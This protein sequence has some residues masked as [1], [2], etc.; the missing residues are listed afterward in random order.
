MEVV[1]KLQSAKQ[2]AQDTLA[3]E[4][5]VSESATG[6][7][8][9]SSH[10][11]MLKVR[12][13][14]LSLVI[15]CM[16]SD[17]LKLAVTS[18]KACVVEGVQN[19]EPFIERLGSLKPYAALKACLDGLVDMD[20][21]RSLSDHTKLMQTMK[22]DILGLVK[23]TTSAANKLKKAVDRHRERLAT[24]E[25]HATAAIPLALPPPGTASKDT[26]AKKAA[27]ST[28]SFPEIFSL[29]NLTEISK[30]VVPDGESLSD[31]F[32][33]NN[34]A[35]IQEAIIV[36]LQ[37]TGDKIQHDPELKNAMGMFWVD[38]LVSQ[39]YKSDHGRGSNRYKKCAGCVGPLPFSFC[40]WGSEFQH[41]ADRSCLFGDA[42]QDS[43]AEPLHAEGVHTLGYGS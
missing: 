34:M 40:T 38:F 17:E 12:S 1:E 5:S 43:A 24:R 13:H 7:K 31:A 20:S 16:T 11:T 9:Y 19:F 42:I 25:A 27:T 30:I 3:N 14:I 10:L 8:P 37:A 32:S 29:Q 35:S 28:T 18:Q 41:G 33:K 22:T 23:Q 21:K 36:Q 6:E 39:A 2:C 4:S 15:G 26:G